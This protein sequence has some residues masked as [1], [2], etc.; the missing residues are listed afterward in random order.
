[1]ARTTVAGN[2]AGRLGG[3]LYEKYGESQLTENI[4]SGNEA[5]LLGGGVYLYESH[6]TLKDSVIVDNLAWSSGGGLYVAGGENA[7]HENEVRAN[8][9]DWGGGIYLQESRSTLV[10][11]LVADNRASGGGGGLYVAAGGNRLFH[12]TVVN[13]GSGQSAEGGKGVQVFRG[14]VALANTILAGHA[15]GLYVEGEDT[16]ARLYGTLWDNDEDWA[17]DGLIEHT[18]DYTGSPGFKDTVVGDYH[19]GAESAALDRGVDAG[20]NTDIDAHPRPLPVGGAVD[21][22]ADE[23]TGIDLTPSRKVVDP[24]RVEVGDIV[25]Y[26]IELLNKGYLSAVD[27]ALFDPL[28]VGTTYVSGSAGA[29]SGVLTDSD[30]IRW[31]GTIVPDRGVTLTYQV[32]LNRGTAVE[33]TAVVTDQYGTVT[34]LTTWVNLEHLYLPLITKETG[35]GS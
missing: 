11:T 6:S 29:T 21:L 10:N 12:T 22:G 32:I 19:L 25:T 9:A 7:L 28:P 14:S 26:T 13:N 1:M 18:R 4:F 3:G 34:E 23:F 30:G 33:N 16:A 24:Q 31:A 17:G 8:S 35:L 27:T 2:H 20:V 15:V 5:D